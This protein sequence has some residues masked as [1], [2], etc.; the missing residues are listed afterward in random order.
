MN[1]N[2]FNS[3]NFKLDILDL[4]L[5]PLI[6]GIEFGNKKIVDVDEN[7]NIYVISYHNKIT[8]SFNVEVYKLKIWKTI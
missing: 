1:S 6:T 2:Y 8:N 5:N 4:N 7:G 3:R